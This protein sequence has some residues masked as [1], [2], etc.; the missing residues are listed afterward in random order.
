VYGGNYGVYGASVSKSI[1]PSDVIAGYMIRYG[2]VQVPE[3]KPE[4]ASQTLI[5]NYGETGR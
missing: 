4:L 1:N 2:F 5:I 3:I